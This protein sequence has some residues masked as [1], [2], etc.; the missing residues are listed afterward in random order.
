MP[1]Q[2]DLG[3]D[4]GALKGISKI[5]G[6]GRPLE[7]LALLGVIY[8]LRSA[9][10][11]EAAARMLLSFIIPFYL[12]LS[13]QK[14]CFIRYTTL[15]LPFLC[16]L[17]ARLLEA[18][19]HR[20]R[21]K[22][23]FLLPAALLIVSDSAYRIV[24]HDQ[25][26]SRPDSRNLVS[27]WMKAHI[28]LDSQILF[29]QY[30]LFGRPAAARLYHRRL[31]L[32]LG[33]TAEELK[34]LLPLSVRGVD[35]MVINKAPLPYSR[36]EPGVRKLLESE[37]E[38]VYRLEAYSAAARPVYDLFDAYYVPLAGFKGV[39]RGGPNIRVYRVR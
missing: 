29:P 20:F 23:V 38:P 2:T 34:S 26:L 36:L 39:K 3:Q 25:L 37:G 11:G 12:I 16:L 10:R 28:P 35:F 9:W 13:F 30:Y 14:A 8:A 24:R 6:L 7:A 18:A 33:I 31:S 1:A 15:L 22:P 19:W 32:P 4:I 5:P 21:W 17:A 27:E